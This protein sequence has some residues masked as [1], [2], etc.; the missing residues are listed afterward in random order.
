MLARKPLDPPQEHQVLPVKRIDDIDHDINDHDTIPCATLVS[1]QLD[2][3]VPEVMR[4][5][6]LLLPQVLQR[7]HMPLLR[8]QVGL[9]AHMYRSSMSH[10][11]ADSCS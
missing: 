1:E 10:Q 3:L 5:C 11:S 6:S 2:V 7:V 8:V 4:I 9:M